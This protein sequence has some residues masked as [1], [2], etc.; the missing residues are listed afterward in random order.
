MRCLR[1]RKSA[2]LAESDCGRIPGQKERAYNS[3]EGH[4]V[5]QNQ[6]IKRISLLCG[7]CLLHAADGEKDPDPG[8]I[9]G[10]P[11]AQKTRLA[12]QDRRVWL[13]RLVC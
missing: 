1:H 11:L 3:T 8:T 2:L 7:R 12:H 10:T 4:T 5:K 6:D 9:R 13:H